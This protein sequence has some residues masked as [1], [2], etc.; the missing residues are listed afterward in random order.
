MPG[1]IYKSTLSNMN[2]K[3]RNYCLLLLVVMATTFSYAQDDDSY[4]SKNEL[5]PYRIGLKFG[6][7]MVAGL[8]LEYVTPLWTSRV[9]PFIGFT[10]IGLQIT[11]DAK[12]NFSAFEIGS[13][14][15][16]NG[17]G[18]GRGFYG[19]LAYQSINA[20][21]KQQDYKAEDGKVYQGTATSKISFGGFNTKIGVKVGRTFYFRT[22]LGYS[23]GS[24]PE[25]IVTKGTYNGQPINDRQNIKDDLADTPVLNMG[26]IP[27]FNLGFGFAF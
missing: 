18:D 13:N 5:R 20:T 14:I 22:E 27:L 8:D 9:A 11:D 1:I 3:I 10:S 15:Y 16:F 26:G 19:S 21:L 7:P 2:F 17:R 12:L 4:N 6:T 24:L 25:E 23:F